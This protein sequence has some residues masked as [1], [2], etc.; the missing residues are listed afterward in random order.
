MN[1]DLKD[2]EEHELMTYQIALLNVQVHINKQLIEIK[3]KLD[4][5]EKENKN[6]K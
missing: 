5:I 3:N 4:K 1:I 6:V 2:A